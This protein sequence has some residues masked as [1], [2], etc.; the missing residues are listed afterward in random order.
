M[1]LIDMS[2]SHGQAVHGSKCKFT[3]KFSLFHKQSQKSREKSVLL[4]VN[5][6]K[7]IRIIRIIVALCAMAAPTVA[8]VAGYES[9]FSHMQF[10]TAVLSGAVFWLTAWALIT[11]IYGRIYCSTVCPLGTLQDCVS[12]VGKR[13]P[14]HQGYRF[15]PDR[16]GM[17]LFFLGL[18]IV[19][20]IT[21]W[22]VIPTLLDP[23]SA[24]ARMV[25]EFF[26]RPLGRYGEGVR[27]SLA[28]FS[29][30]AVTVLVIV[31]I[32]WRRGRLLCNTLC[33]VGALLG[34]V[35]YRPVLHPD[36]NTD[37]CINC[38]ECERVCKSECIDLIQH[39]VDT[40]RCVVCFNCM[41][42]CPNHAIT[43]RSGNH[44]LRTP[45]MQPTDPELTLNDPL[46]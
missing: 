46:P 23:Y 36:I 18:V 11:F 37:L 6:Y 14:R 29:V 8:L 25:E 31:G 41:A 28:S 5:M 38:G 22:A 13:F 17:R 45:L 35:A 4:S 24:Y 10:M 27:H 15:H 20:M 16:P 40:S 39:T 30:A 1:I 19:C 26:V 3:I 12:A 44:R 7:S 34:I 2:D 21:G 9:V 33:P 32:A 43:Y 42:A